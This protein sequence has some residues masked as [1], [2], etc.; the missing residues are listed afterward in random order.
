MAAQGG[1]PTT[2]P[3]T[4]GP[5][6]GI[7]TYHRYLIFQT[8]ALTWGER[9]AVPIISDLRWHN[10]LDKNYFQM[11]CL[12]ASAGIAQIDWDVF[13]RKD[14]VEDTLPYNSG[15]QNFPIT[16]GGAGNYDVQSFPLGG[17]PMPSSIEYYVRLKLV[18]DPGQGAILVSLWATPE[19]WYTFRQLAQGSFG[20]F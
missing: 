12:N 4:R 19:L 8:Q 17:L 10:G 18:A 5:R 15:T 20:P 9:E 7:N 11:L 14:N 16:A 3:I 1:L 2:L 6:E 13:L